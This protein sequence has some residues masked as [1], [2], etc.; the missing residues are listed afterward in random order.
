MK[1]SFILLMMAGLIYFSSC[2]NK[3]DN[4]NAPP[5]DSVSKGSYLQ[6]QF[7]TKS[8]YFNDLILNSTPVY[9]LSAGTVSTDQF[10]T[11]FI[12]SILLKDFTSK[13]MALDLSGVH[14]SATGVFVVKNNASTL[15]DYSSGQN[16]KYSIGVGSVFKITVS[17]TYYTEGTMSLQLRYNYDTTR[18]TGSFKIYK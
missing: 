17:G 14:D 5:V 3:N 6:L 1:S 10:D 16:R 13:Q 7:D 18:A 15:T 8:F 9:G 2:N 12:G 11:S 4:L